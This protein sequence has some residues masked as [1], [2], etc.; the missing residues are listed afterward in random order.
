MPKNGLALSVVIFDRGFNEESEA[1]DN[2]GESRM[3]Y[4]SEAH[5]VLLVYDAG[6]FDS[7]YGVMHWYE[8]IVKACGGG[9]SSESELSVLPTFILVGAKSDLVP[10][11]N[12]GGQ[13]DSE[14]RGGGGA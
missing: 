10:S 14:Q 3:K 4:F 9:K 2:T 11:N 7:F 12:N 1:I 5:V 8:E 6:N 13:P